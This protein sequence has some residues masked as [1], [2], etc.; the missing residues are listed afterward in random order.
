MEIFNST[1][2]LVIDKSSGDDILIKT[3]SKSLKKGRYVPD[4]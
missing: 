1:V 4:S 2:N 3:Y